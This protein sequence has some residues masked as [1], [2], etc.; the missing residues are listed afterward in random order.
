M[1]HGE[2]YGPRPG[3]TKRGDSSGKRQRT[4]RSQRTEVVSMYLL[5]PASLSFLS[6]VVGRSGRSGGETQRKPQSKVRPLVRPDC[7]RTLMTEATV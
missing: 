5:T 6:F 3:P 4:E 7:V 1:N 2:R